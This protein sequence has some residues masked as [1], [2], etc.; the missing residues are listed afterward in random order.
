MNERLIGKTTGE[1]FLR[2]VRV[3]LINPDNLK[4]AK[5]HLKNG[6]L[7]VYFN[8]FARFDTVV[9]GKII[10]E[11]LTSLDNVASW[12]AMKYLDC[13]RN[14]II[15]TLLQS[16][17]KAYGVTLL[18]IVQTNDKESYPNPNK[19]N[20]NSLNQ[21]IAYLALPGHVLA[22]APEG[23]RSDTGQLLKAEPG[24][25]TLIKRGV[26]VHALPLAGIHSR[27]QPLVT[28][29]TVIVGKPFSYGEIKAEQEQNPDQSISD[30]AMRRIAALL[31]EENRGYYLSLNSIS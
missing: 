8:H 4:V 6:S 10:R 16:W 1:A 18:P 28:K 20:M 24:F 13:S 15:S 27:V 3:E 23:T 17:E 19:T 26:N 29:T 30:L 22:V 5:E 11:N 21:A 7:I 9:Y 12:V 31:P 25:G 14:R 2:S